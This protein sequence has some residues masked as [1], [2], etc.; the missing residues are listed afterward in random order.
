MHD[1]Q[2]L[3]NAAALTPETAFEM[4]RRWYLMSQQLTALRASEMLTR[5]E[6]G[7]FYFPAP[8]E[9]TNTLPLGDGFALKFVAGYTRTPDTA[10]VLATEETMRAAGI[11]F[12]A[13][14][15]WKPTLRKRAYDALTPQQ[16]LIV[17]GTLSITDST[18]S[19]KV[20]PM[21]DTDAPTYDDS[22]ARPSTP[23]PPHV[24]PRTETADGEKPKRKRRTKA[25]MEAAR[26]A[27]A[28]ARDNP[29]A[30][31]A[32]AVE[33]ATAA[34]PPPPPPVAQFSAPPPPPVAQP[35]IPAP[36]QT[37]APT[38]PPAFADNPAFA[39]PPPPV[40]ASEP[41]KRVRK[42]A[43]TKTATTRKGKK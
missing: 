4:L 42:S 3:A 1:P 34:L 23:K 6:I 13:L 29:G 20:A 17:D 32:A 25:E 12:D 16:R 26:A 21:N 30:A 37:V 9:G 27:E 11:D 38:L 40:A 22:E 10:A 36:P 43:A 18:P 33:T 24:K 31:V 8:R 15:D 41:A 28:A 2:A 7:A 19:L 35:A 14:F 39:I 5:K